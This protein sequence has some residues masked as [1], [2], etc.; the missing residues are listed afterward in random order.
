MLS[1]SPHGDTARRREPS[2]AL[3]AWFAARKE[4]FFLKLNTVDVKLRYGNTET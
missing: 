1:F 3:S 2:S 4:L